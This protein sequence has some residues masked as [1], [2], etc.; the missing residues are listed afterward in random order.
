[1]FSMFLVV[2]AAS[3]VIETDN[4]LPEVDETL[5]STEQAISNGVKPV[6][7]GLY[8]HQGVW[9]QNLA[10]NAPFDA[11]VPPPSS[12]HVVGTTPRFVQE[13]Y[14][15]AKVP[16]TIAAGLAPAQ[17]SGDLA[18][19][20]WTGVQQAGPVD[21]RWLADGSNLFQRQTFYEGAAWMKEKTPFLVRTRD[22]QGHE[23]SHLK[24]HPGKDNKWKEGDDFLARR[25]VAR[26]IT[27]HCAAVGDCSNPEAQTFAEVLIQLQGNLR[28]DRDDKCETDD[29]DD[30]LKMPAEA[31]SLEVTWPQLPGKVWSVPVVHDDPDPDFGYGLKIQLEVVNTPVSGYFMPGDNVQV[32]VTYT[33]DAGHEL[34]PDH[35]LPS[36]FEAMAWL[37]SANGMRYL[38][39]DDAPQ[40]Y[41]AH[42]ATQ[43]AMER[44][45]AGPLQGMGRPGTNMIY[46]FFQHDLVAATR[47]VDGWTGLVQETPETSIMFGCAGG[48]LGLCLT[49]S[50]DIY[51]FTL[52]ADAEAGTYVS[53]IKARRYW[54]GEPQ[55][56]AEKVH[57]Q[58]GTLTETLFS[59]FPIPP[60]V[61]S[62]C[63]EC[64]AGRARLDAV[65]H[66][67]TGVNG[68]DESCVAC[69]TDSLPFE[70]DAPLATRL[71][72]VHRSPRAK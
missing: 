26:V 30:S 49:P 23:L 64:H 48:D 22:A 56:Q 55:I 16:S 41:W 15:T 70:P 65:W 25:F 37:P 71:I 63:R 50:P 33:D 19:L 44:Y 66:A 10:E 68:V 51:D 40:L 12:L 28:D 4:S 45:L 61:D 43:G 47:A 3:C 7:L 8:F 5:G 39:F 21:W 42:K 38:A 34:F 20:D 24:V 58:V 53:G 29:K 62:D 31:A 27:V 59:G 46:D 69:H 54:A 1:M 67:P 14:I 36:Y 13:M 18:G 52:P 35:Y 72:Q 17:T 60:E 32:R 2:I 6:G 11:Y 57:F 9:N